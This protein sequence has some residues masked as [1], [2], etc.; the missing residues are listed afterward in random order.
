MSE[1]TIAALFIGG[2]V[3]YFTLRILPIFLAHN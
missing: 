3:L 1:R 2:T